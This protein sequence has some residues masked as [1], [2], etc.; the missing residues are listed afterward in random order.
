M[1]TGFSSLRASSPRLERGELA[2]SGRPLLTHF[3]CIRSKNDLVGPPTRKPG[4]RVEPFRKRPG[5]PRPPSLRSVGQPSGG[6]RSALAGVLAFSDGCRLG[7]SLRPGGLF[8]CRPTLADARVVGVSRHRRLATA[9]SPR[10]SVAVAGKG[11]RLRRFI[12]R[13]AT[14]TPAAKPGAEV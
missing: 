3:H 8:H 10:P 11:M 5:R 1:G 9:T 13:C 14:R 6:H 12:C 2:R 4:R 7:G